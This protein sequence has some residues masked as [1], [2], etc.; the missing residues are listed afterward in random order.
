[1]EAK[2]WYVIIVWE[3]QLKTTLNET[4]SQV[5]AEIQQ[6]G[7]AFRTKQED[8]RRA[9]EEYQKER[10]ALR[11]REVAIRAEL[12]ETFRLNNLDKLYD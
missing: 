12:Y 6:N 10:R 8:K 4:V 7:A 3:C 11:N 9:R 1:M 5:E 2:G